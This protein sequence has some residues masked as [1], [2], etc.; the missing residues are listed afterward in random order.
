MK[1]KCIIFDL[2]GTLFD[3]QYGILEAYNY[4]LDYM[5]YP[6]IHKKDIKNYIGPSVK[7]VFEE[8]YKMREAL[9]E[10][11]TKMYRELYVDKFISNSIMY[12]GWFQILKDIKEKDAI[13]GIAT[14]KTQKQLDALLKIFDLQEFF[15]IAIGAK[16]DGSLS[17]SQMLKLIKNKYKSSI[18]D[19]YMIGDTEGDFWASKDNEYKFVFAEYGYGD[20]E[21]DQIE[22][23]LLK[24]SDIWRIL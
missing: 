10:K 24:P 14:M 7:K 6:L 8:K 21:S 18:E 19:F 23:S 1:K 17:K 20:V 11:A 2:D 22:G 4:V 9:A 13:I 5:G 16:E 15:H 3:T 12:E